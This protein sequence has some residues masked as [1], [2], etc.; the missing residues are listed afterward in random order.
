MSVYIRRTINASSLQTNADKHKS[1]KTDLQV[2]SAELSCSY[3]VSSYIVALLIFKP[4][5][6][7]IDNGFTNAIKYMPQ[8]L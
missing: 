4:L 7:C 8:A 2:K 1:F 6:N 3:I 5:T